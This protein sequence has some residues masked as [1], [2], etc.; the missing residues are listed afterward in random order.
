VFKLL[1]LSREGTELKYHVR[2]TNSTQTLQ[3]EEKEQVQLSLVVA[4]QIEKQDIQIDENGKVSLLQ[5]VAKDQRVSVEDTLDAPWAQ[6]SQC[7]Y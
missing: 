1:S 2:E 5:G 4:Q 7:P 6:K 3:Q